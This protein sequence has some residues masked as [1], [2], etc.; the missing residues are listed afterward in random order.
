MI[1]GST[2]IGVQLGAA[3]TLTHLGDR[4]K[5]YWWKADALVSLTDPK[6][7]AW[8]LASYARD[9][10]SRVE[11]SQAHRQVETVRKAAYRY[12]AEAPPRHRRLPLRTGCILRTI[13]TS[14]V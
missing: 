11:H 13:G 2:D 5:P 1:G 14:T 4:F 10:R 8:F 9:A 3:G 12:A 7:V 6:D